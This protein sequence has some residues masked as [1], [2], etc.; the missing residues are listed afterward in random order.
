MNL[1]NLNCWHKW[2]Q[3]CITQWSKLLRTGG[4]M[5][6]DSR[7]KVIG[8]RGICGALMTYRL[9]RCCAMLAGEIPHWI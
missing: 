6:S 9:A 4:R 5:Y 7:D 3:Q 8:H 1:K 2:E